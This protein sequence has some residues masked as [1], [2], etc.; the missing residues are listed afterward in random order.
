MKQPIHVIKNPSGFT[1]IFNAPLT[2]IPEV[3]NEKI[4]GKRSVDSTKGRPDSTKA[5]PDSSKDTPRKS[6]NGTL[7]NG[8]H[9]II[10]PIE[11][12]Y[13]RTQFAKNKIPLFSTSE[14]IDTI[15]NELNETKIEFRKSYNEVHEKQTGLIQGQI[16]DRVKMLKKNELNH[17]GEFVHQ[18]KLA[19]KAFDDYKKKPKVDPNI[20]KEYK[21]R[22]K[23][24]DIYALPNNKKD[25]MLKTQAGYMFNG[26][27]D[28][29]GDPKDPNNKDGDNEKKDSK[30]GSGK[31]QTRNVNIYSLKSGDAGSIDRRSYA[32]ASGSM[33]PCK[34]FQDHVI[35]DSNTSMTKINGKIGATNFLSFESIPLN[36]YYKGS[37]VTASGLKKVQTIVLDKNLMHLGKEGD[38]S[39]SKIDEYGS[40]IG[41]YDGKLKYQGKQKQF[42][43]SSGGLKGDVWKPSC[44]L[45]RQFA[46][47]SESPTNNNFFYPKGSKDSQGS[48]R[49][50]P[51]GI[52]YRIKDSSGDVSIRQKGSFKSSY[53]SNHNENNR[54]DIIKKG[55]KSKRNANVPLKVKEEDIDPARKNWQYFNQ[56][57]N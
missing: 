15:Q 6:A 45:S 52:K 29:K 5:L 55:G 4:I 3:A 22:I 57:H 19:Y 30:K 7:I 13:K 14:Q 31:S 32:I 37:I 8:G 26:D 50:S 21:N 51:N 40:N 20:Y 47:A 16:L 10:D 28:Q 33:S 53:Q 41:G 49:R 23:N 48:S 1:P 43:N 11:M 56:K 12:H 36:D 35:T 39:L 54:S 18:Y 34:L 44:S 17:K 27:K 24:T 25:L 9:K 38:R 2:K 42:A 46:E